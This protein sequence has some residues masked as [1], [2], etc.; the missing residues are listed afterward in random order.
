MLVR[1]LVAH[2]LD[3]CECEDERWAVGSYGVRILQV[4]MYSITL[5]Y[6]TILA[7]YI[8]LVDGAILAFII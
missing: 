4:R 1:K 6:E 7:P 2:T 5:Y 3:L 8:P